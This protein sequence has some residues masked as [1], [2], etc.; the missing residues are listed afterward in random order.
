MATK[1]NI[2]IDQG[3]TFNTQIQLS[4]EAGNPLDLSAYTANSQIRRWYN[5]SVEVDFNV[6]LSNGVINLALDANTTT[7][8]TRS[9]YVYDVIV[10]D[11]SNNITRVVEG[12]ITVNPSVTHYVAPNTTY[13]MVVNNVY[14]AYKTGD[15]IY[16]SGASSNATAIIYNTAIDS[17][18]S[19]NNQ[20]QIIAVYTLSVYNVSG[21]FSNTNSNS[22]IDSISNANG[23]LISI[24]QNPVENN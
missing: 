17:F 4:D 10:T 13:T 21:T 11:G 16:Q 3:T 9:R 24:T 8:L 15:L 5:S 2:S 1:A 19:S 14:G 23:T 18:D 12:V 6:T 22:V 20:N 7:N